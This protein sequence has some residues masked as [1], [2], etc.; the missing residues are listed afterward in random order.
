MNGIRY[1]PEING[2]V[3]SWANL[4]VNIAG[5]PVTGITKI[6]YKDSQT[7]ESIYGAGQ[8]PV[9]RGYGRIECSASITLLRDELE[10][11]RAASDTGR[12]QDIAPFDIIVSFLPIGGQLLTTHKIRNAQFKDDGVD[13]NEGDTSNTSDCELIIS[14]IEWR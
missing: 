13:A 12:L 2:V 3:H 9:G 14:H 7:I 6:S 1:I 5:V 11:I 10:A 4:V 8:R